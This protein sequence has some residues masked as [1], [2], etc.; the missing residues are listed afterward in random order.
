MTQA[1]DSPNRSTVASG[2]RFLT[3][4]IG[5]TST[6]W[7]AA[8]CL[9]RCHLHRAGRG[10][11]LARATS[12][13]LAAALALQPLPRR[14]VIAEVEDTRGAIV[15]DVVELKP[16]LVVGI[17]EAVPHA[18]LFEFFP[19]ALEAAGGAAGAAI[20][21]PALAIYHGDPHSD[22]FDV[23]VGFPVSDE[24]PRDGVVTELLPGGPAARVTHTGSYETLGEAYTELAAAL[25]E[26]GVPWTI[27]WETYVVGMGDVSSPDELVTEVVA[28]L[29]HG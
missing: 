5:W 21:G 27:A 19:R 10:D 23:T 25:A 12:V 13:A 18:A 26:R 8:A 9:G 22:A 28:P 7:A 3:E 6:V 14:T 11:D 4:L 15:V 1:A 2:V 29:T 17:R 20:S 24:A 16:Q